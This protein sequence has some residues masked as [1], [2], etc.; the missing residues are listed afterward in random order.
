MSKLPLI[1]GIMKYISEKNSLFCM[2]GHKQGKGFLCTDEGKK[3]YDNLIKFDLTEVDGLDNLHHAEGII[4]EAEERLSSFYGTKKSY[5]LVNGSTSGNLAMIFACFNEGDK[6]IV[7]RNCH[8]SIFN[9]IIMRKLKPVYI[10]NDFNYEMNA[11]LAIDEEYFLKLLD[12][13]IDAKGVII[14]YPNYY[15]VCCNLEF[16]AGEAKK[17]GMKVIVDS[18]HGAHFGLCE[19]LPKSAVKLGCDMVVMSAHK[20]LP[21]LTQTAYLHLCSDEIEVDKL[22]FYVSSFLTTSPS[23][24][25]MASMDYARFY[26][27]EK[28]YSEYKKLIN[29]CNKY[30]EKIDKIRGMHILNEADLNNKN[31]SIDK[32]R[33]VIN[34]CKG[35]S[36]FKLYNYLKENFIQPEM[37]DSQNVILIFSPFNC[38]EEFKKLYEVLIKCNIEELEDKSFD[39]KELS[40]PSMEMAP[41]DVLNSKKEVMDIYEAEG[42]ICADAVVPYPPGVPIIMPGEVISKE[43]I[44]EINYYIKN[45]ALV[46]GVNEGKVN[47][48]IRG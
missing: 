36:G 1:D 28:G 17:R 39:L 5:F 4:K 25:F 19:E 3:F 33:F 34:V 23:Y 43:I 14:T 35:Y 47:T 9:S 13:N 48:V 21:S 45:N 26:I 40:I 30:A 12:E 16:I 2:P 32:T 11:P 18:A 42:E 31:Q 41:G 38:E 6:V 22:D 24:V 46:M 29:I 37:C 15:G 7:E 44:E 8:R 27:E 20:T 10:K